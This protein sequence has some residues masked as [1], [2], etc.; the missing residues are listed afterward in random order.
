MGP[1]GPWLEAHSLG[2]GSSI[3]GNGVFKR[4]D[5]VGGPGDMPS[6]WTKE[7]C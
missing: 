2:G 4:R 5:L 6:K 1:E 3:G 7:T